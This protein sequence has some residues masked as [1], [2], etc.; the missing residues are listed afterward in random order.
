MEAFLPGCFTWIVK[1]LVGRA[2]NK[3]G[4]RS[5]HVRLEADH[6]QEDTPANERV[7]LWDVHLQVRRVLLEEG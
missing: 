4:I 7:G 2:Q 6:R 5:G 1:L 3:E